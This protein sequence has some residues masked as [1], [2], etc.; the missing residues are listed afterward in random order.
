YERA[1]TAHGGALELTGTWPQGAQIDAGGFTSGQVE[2]IDVRGDGRVDRIVGARALS[3]G[4]GL[5]V[6]V[7]LALA[8]GT[9]EHHLVMVERGAV[10]AP[11]RVVK[12]SPSGLRQG[13]NQAQYLAIADGV[14]YNAA[15]DLVTYR[16][17][18]MSAQLVDVQ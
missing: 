10:P 13:S 1:L 9:V 3:L 12:D 2:V 5:P 17:G 4:P 18:Q 6:T 15:R 14:L 8:P 16:R 11:A 7:V